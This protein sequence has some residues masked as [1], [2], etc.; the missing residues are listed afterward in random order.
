MEMKSFG[1]ALNEQHGVDQNSKREEMELEMT[2]KR[3]ERERDMALE[4]EQRL[5]MPWHS[6]AV[7]GESGVSAMA[8]A[9]MKNGRDASLERTRT[10]ES[11]VDPKRPWRKKACGRLK[12]LKEVA[13]GYKSR[14]VKLERDLWWTMSDYLFL[15]GR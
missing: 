10:F 9:E 12:Q 11:K 7:Q 15:F 5:E 14:I 8:A 1:E 6:A 2:R 13:S 4:K 3:D